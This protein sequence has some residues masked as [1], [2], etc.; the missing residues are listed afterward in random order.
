M[1]EHEEATTSS[2][3]QVRNG[4]L[5][6]QKPKNAKKEKNKNKSTSKRMAA[7]QV[8]IDDMV[9]SGSGCAPRTNKR[10]TV[11]KQLLL[12]H[13]GLR[14]KSLI[15]VKQANSRHS[16]SS[17]YT[18]GSRQTHWQC[19]CY[20]GSC[21]QQ[22]RQRQQKKKRNFIRFVSPTLSSPSL[23]KMVWNSI[24]FARSLLPLPLQ[25]IGSISLAYCFVLVGYVIFFFF[26]SRRQ[27]R[28]SSHKTK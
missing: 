1:N 5:S 26:V 14:Q 23:D 8:Q 16:R 7:E 25:C 24:N 6:S 4:A 17:K 12:L 27:N 11:I 28:N 9:G 19:C 15:I 3:L 21:K 10:Q 2:P 22:R 18:H 20:P 13:R